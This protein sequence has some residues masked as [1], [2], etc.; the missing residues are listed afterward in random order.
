MALHM[1]TTVDNPFDPFTQWD[2][3]VNY[4]EAAGYFTN[5]LLARIARLSPDLSDADEIVAIE[6]AIDE[7][8]EENVNGLYRKIEIPL[9]AVA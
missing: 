7:I 5:S 8:V 2:E 9:E 1:L 4:D 6:Q 3:W